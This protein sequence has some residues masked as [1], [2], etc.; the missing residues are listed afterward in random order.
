M[1]AELAHS[2]VKASPA[3]LRGRVTPHHR[4]LSQLYFE[5]VDAIDAAIAEIDREVDVA[6]EQ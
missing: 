6:H 3:A 5:Q 4:F 2:R 1:L